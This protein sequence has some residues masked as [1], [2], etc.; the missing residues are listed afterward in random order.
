ME[1]PGEEHRA[2]RT[3]VLDSWRQADFAEQRASTSG[4][5]GVRVGRTAARDMAHLSAHVLVVVTR[6]GRAWEG[7]RSADGPRQRR[8]D[9][10]RVTRKSST[11]PLGPPST[12]SATN[13]S[14]LFT[15]RAAWK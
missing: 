11:A 10:E 13:C 14:R 1:A 6:Q 8:H 12:R 7:R 2:N 4:V 3:R 15:N 5:S 9:A